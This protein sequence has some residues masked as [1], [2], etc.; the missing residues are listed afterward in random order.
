MKTSSLAIFFATFA[1]PFESVIVFAA[2]GFYR[3]RAHNPSSCEDMAEMK[4]QRSSLIDVL[5]EISD[6]N[7]LA[8]AITTWETEK[9][10]RQ[11]QNLEANCNGGRIRLLRGARDRQQNG[12]GTGAKCDGGEDCEK[13]RL[14]PQMNGDGDGMGR[15][16]GGGGGMF[17]TGECDGKGCSRQREDGQGRGRGDRKGSNGLFTILRDISCGDGDI[18]DVDD[19]LEAMEQSQLVENNNQPAMRLVAALETFVEECDESA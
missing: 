7:E 4:I 18:E 6:G 16:G 2:P 13:Q 17:G 9:N 10:G 19:I 3:Q 12:D 11:Q 15:I 5:E 8:A 14:G 1:L